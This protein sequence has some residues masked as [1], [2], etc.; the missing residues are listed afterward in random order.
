MQG[1]LLNQVPRVFMSSVCFRVS[2]R[3]TST[4]HYKVESGEKS[5]GEA[6]SAAAAV[7][8]FRWNCSRGLG[9][10]ECGVT[11]SRKL[12]GMRSSAPPPQ[13]PQAINFCFEPLHINHNRKANSSPRLENSR[14]L[15]VRDSKSKVSFK[16][17]FTVF[18]LLGFFSPFLPCVFCF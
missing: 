9:L 7:T 18:D 10:K 14:D 3:I 1:G 5:R 13:L 12:L 8:V 16:R 17:D 6:C 2:H 15:P 4:Q 11:N